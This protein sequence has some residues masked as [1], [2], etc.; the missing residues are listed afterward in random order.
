MDSRPA[1]CTLRPSLA[2]TY[3][4]VARGAVV[5][6]LATAPQRG[7][8]VSTVPGHGTHDGGPSSVVAL[9]YLDARHRDRPYTSR[10]IVLGIILGIQMTQAQGARD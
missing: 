9:R 10:L 2:D 5:L 4:T 3:L 7:L 6:R 1:E 8:T